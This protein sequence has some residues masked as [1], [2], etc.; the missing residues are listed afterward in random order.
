MFLRAVCMLVSGCH[1]SGVPANTPTAG[2]LSYC[3]NLCGLPPPRAACILPTPGRALALGEG[4][5]TH[6]APMGSAIHPS[7]CVDLQMPQSAR[8]TSLPDGSQ[9]GGGSSPGVWL[10]GGGGWGALRG[11]RSP[12]L[13]EPDPD[14]QWGVFS[15]DE[16]LVPLPSSRDGRGLQEAWA[17][18]GFQAVSTCKDGGR[19]ES[20][21]LRAGVWELGCRINQHQ[22][23][24]TGR[25]S[26]SEV[27]C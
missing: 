22:N 18:E 17:G 16:D 20:Q 1:P 2:P 23:K 15:Q 8:S 6:R 21:G 4:S 10:P 24:H 5:C 3:W 7:V 25:C 9:G 19:A 27:T 12:V 14:A 13:R 11:G 26:A